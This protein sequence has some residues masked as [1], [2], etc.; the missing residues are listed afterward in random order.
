MESRIRQESVRTVRERVLVRYI[1]SYPKMSPY[2]YGER[3]GIHIIDILQTL[4]C[5]KKV[6]NFL[7]QSK[8]KFE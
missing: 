1:V 7:K 4:I 3:N 8:K 5:I 2:I 6:C